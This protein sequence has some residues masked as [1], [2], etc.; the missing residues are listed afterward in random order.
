[1]KL[2][3]GARPVGHETDLSMRMAGLGADGEIL[4]QQEG[5]GLDLN[6]R[7]DALWMGIKSDAVERDADEGGR[8]GAANANVTRLR[9][10]L[11]GSKR[12][13]AGAGELTPSIQIGLRHDAGDAERGHGLE[14]GGGVQY[15]GDGFTLS[16]QIRGLVAHE[17]S[18]YRSW[19]ASGE[20]NIHRGRD[21]RGLAF[22]VAPSW[23]VSQSQTDRLWTSDKIERAVGGADNPEARVEAELGY[24]ISFG[25]AWGLVTPYTGV[26]WAQDDDQ[27]TRIG[28]KWTPGRETT[29]GIEARR[30]DEGTSFVTRMR[31]RW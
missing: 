26:S 21:G 12:I 30:N 22:K 25:Q 23:G 29:L 24:G 6:L 14:V 15:Q 19:G 16:G 8:L 20:V 10:V 5:N 28:A 27:T 17:V 18:S 7:A 3:Y 31:M 9:L 11:D 1:M 4:A 2:D 13:E